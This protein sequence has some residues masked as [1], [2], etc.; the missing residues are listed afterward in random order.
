MAFKTVSHIALSLVLLIPMMLYYTQQ[1]YRPP[2]SETTQPLFQ[3]ITYERRIHTSPRPVVLHVVT[4]DLRM[5][6]LQPLVTPNLIATSLSTSST[7][8]QKVSIQAQRTRDFLEQFEVQVAVNAN[9]FSPFREKTAWNFYPH[10]GDR[11]YAGG[12]AIGNGDRYSIPRH[13]RPALCFRKLTP[14]SSHTAHFELDGTCPDN[15]VQAVSGRDILVRDGNLMTKFPEQPDDKPYPRTAVGVDQAGHTLWL[16]IVD[17]KQPL[18]SEGILLSEL[19]QVFE[20]LGADG[21]IALDGGG[22]ATL[23]VDSE[24]GSTILNAP[25]HTKWP[26]RERP[27]ANH[28][29]FYAQPIVE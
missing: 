28:L 1:G 21:A 4:I 18:Y 27:V 29:G 2:Q 20:R 17:G 10:T 14:T 23:V 12:E 6:G 3:G 15:T 16:V 13:Y 26:M 9:Y 7:D 11:V 19:A 22:S 24:S 5:A 8:T 25:I